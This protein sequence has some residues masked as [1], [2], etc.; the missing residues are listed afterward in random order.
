MREVLFIVEEKV[1]IKVLRYFFK[2]LKLSVKMV[3]PLRKDL[4]IGRK[5]CDLIILD[6][7][8][9][10]RF[11]SVII[12]QFKKQFPNLRVACLVQKDSRIRKILGKREVHHFFADDR[13]IR[14]HEVIMGLRQ[15]RRSKRRKMKR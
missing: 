5:R 8:R 13:L 11:L 6:A 10:P 9:Q 4:S 2:G 1:S 3:G 12:G 7:S 15:Q 14:I